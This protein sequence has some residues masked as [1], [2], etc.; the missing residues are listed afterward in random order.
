MTP[1][2]FPEISFHA[3]DPLRQPSQDRNQ[4][5]GADFLV[6]APPQVVVD[7]V[8]L[9]AAV[10]E[11]HRGRPPEVAVAAQ[12]QDSHVVRFLSEGPV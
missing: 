1:I 3:V 8:D 5:V 6:R 9:V 7:D 12:D 10:G 4:R 11:P 2:S